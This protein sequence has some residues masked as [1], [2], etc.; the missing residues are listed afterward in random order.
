[1]TWS[2][3][4][5]TRSSK[6]YE[7]T[8]SCT[9]QLI[10]ILTGDKVGDAIGF[11]ISMY[12]LYNR[13]DIVLLILLYIFLS[14]I[15]LL[16]LVIAIMG[17]TYSR[18]QSESV[19]EFY[20]YLLENYNEVS[21]MSDLQK[22]PPPFTFVGLLIFLYHKLVKKLVLRNSKNPLGAYI[23]KYLGDRKYLDEH[24]H[25]RYIK[26]TCFFLWCA[27]MPLFALL[28]IPYFWLN[29]L[30]YIVNV[31]RKLKTGISQIISLFFI[32]LLG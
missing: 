31:D 26:A 32:M 19:G 18:I 16:N 24:I 11:G 21:H 5:T 1:M 3:V 7:E 22:V 2:I 17:G 27:V 15:L 29:F 30:R 14:T 25:S 8:F 9:A 12:E 13:P 10:A 20:F 6:R 23:V 28:M 4:G